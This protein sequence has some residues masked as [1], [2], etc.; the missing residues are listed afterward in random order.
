MAFLAIFTLVFWP[1]L[2]KKG[3]FYCLNNTCRFSILPPPK[4]RR[5]G[6]LKKKRVPGTFCSPGTRQKRPFLP[7]RH[8]EKFSKI[9]KLFYFFTQKN[10][11]ENEFQFVLPNCN[12]CL[13]SFAC[14]KAA[15]PMNRFI[16]RQRLQFDMKSV[17]TRASCFLNRSAVNYERVASRTTKEIIYTILENKQKPLHKPKEKQYATV[18]PQEHLLMWYFFLV[19]LLATRS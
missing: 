4:A 7:Y 13:H 18:R 14:E 11:D 17:L 10:S 5:G 15:M 2:A 9:F 3:L 19:V 16:E 1:F 6:C 8:D 12:H